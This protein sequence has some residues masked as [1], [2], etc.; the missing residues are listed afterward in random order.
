MVQTRGKVSKPKRKDNPMPASSIAAND[1]LK[2]VADFSER[3]DLHST[4]ESGAVTSP[5]VEPQRDRASS[6][7]SSYLSNLCKQRGYP[8]DVVD[9]TVLFAD[10]IEACVF[11]FCRKPVAHSYLISRTSVLEKSNTRTDLLRM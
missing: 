6:K 5:Q 1:S 7:P 2:S 9:P 4:L 10:E 11:T 8:E 3:M